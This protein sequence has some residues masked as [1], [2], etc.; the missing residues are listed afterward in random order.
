MTGSRPTK[1]KRRW[2]QFSLRTLLVFVLAAGLALGLLGRWI[3]QAQDQRMAV[4][5]L[6][7]SGAHV[8]CRNTGGA[9]SNALLRKLFGDEALPVLAV[10]FLGFPV[11]DADLIHLKGLTN[12]RELHLE[13]SG[14]T[15]DGLMHLE[16]LTGLEEL[17][18]DGTHVT[19]EGVVHLKGLTNLQWITLDG[20]D[21]TDA[22]LEHLEGLNNLLILE[23]Y[24]TQVTDDGVKKLREALPN[25]WIY[26]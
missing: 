11:I 10:D 13:F 15:D 16:G 19:G 23:L 22:E 6:R 14:I 17:F 3:R 25:C 18:L 20:S 24:H 26:R 21:V 8:G 1:T 7:R 5:E 9:L 4:I 12:L 2:Y